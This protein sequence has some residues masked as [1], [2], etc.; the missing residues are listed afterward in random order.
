MTSIINV[1]K[2][3]L[4]KT[5]QNKP[6]TS[7]EVIKTSQKLDKHIVSIMKKQYKNKKKT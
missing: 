5:A 3:D 1:L 2:K 6:L 7:I 4:I